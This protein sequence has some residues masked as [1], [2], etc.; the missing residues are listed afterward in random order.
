[1]KEFSA[2]TGGRY[3]YIDDIINLQDLSLAF[4]SI[5]DNCDNFIISGCEIS[6]TSISEGY[7]YINGKIRH[8][9]G[10][11]GITTWPQYIYESNKTET[12]TYASGYDK[13][14]RNVYGC[15]LAKLVPSTVDVLTGETPGFIK[16][17]STGGIGI[18]DALFG[19]Y[20]LLLKSQAGVQ[21]VADHIRFN[22]GIAIPSSR[23]LSTR[24]VAITSLNNS[25]CQIGYEGDS[26][27]FKS[28]N[29]TGSTIRFEI[30]KDGVILISVN[31]SRISISKSQLATEI[32]MLMPKC[33][34]GNI[35]INGNHIFNSKD[36][37]D[38]AP[39]Y[40]NMMGFNAGNGLYRDTVIGNGKEKAI[41][42]IQG[43]TGAVSLSGNL[44]V[45]NNVFLTRKS[46][47]V[48]SEGTNNVT[49]I[50]LNL[51]GNAYEFKSSAYNIDLIGLNYVN[52]GP[53]IREG[54]RPL[55]DKYVTNDKFNA[56]LKNKANANDVY[57]KREVDETFANVDG[58]L[59]QF[60]KSHTNKELRD[61]IGAV[62]TEELEE[63]L[64]DTGWVSV[65]DETYTF[66]YA[67]QIGN[68]VSLQGYIELP[69]REGVVFTIPENIGAPKY[70][71]VFNTHVGAYGEMMWQSVIA[72]GSKKCVVTR[73]DIG[74]PESI[75]FSITYMI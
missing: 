8:F 43:K 14:G 50:G 62:G 45:A 44:N 21:E 39:I 73:S 12:V 47:I 68:I 69:P 19:K 38:N 1:M 51:L 35:V 42:S 28:T 3:T 61:S 9:R 75:S 48:W 37:N 7:V 34:A 5:F 20:S 27:V 41:V 56:D 58:D 17:E 40:I 72:G 16:L 32:P 70:N 52:I 46:F 65:G 53:T 71:V 67:R 57:S 60:K 15:A 23:G 26:L 36:G 55:S 4:T 66:I 29:T 59:S 18:K 33:T 24:S 31:N 63:K 54:G 74:S 10:A 49:T 25:H 2:Q 11:S 64:K 30:S 6:G 22:N 13:V